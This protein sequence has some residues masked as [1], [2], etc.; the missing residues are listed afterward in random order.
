MNKLLLEYLDFIKETPIEDIS[1]IGDPN[2]ATNFTKPEIKMLQSEKYQK[3]IRNAFKNTPFVFDIVFTYHD[4][5]DAN[6]EEDNDEYENSLSIALK[7]AQIN[8]KSK[9]G[10][11]TFVSLG[12]LSSEQKLP[13]TPWILA[14]KIGHAITDYGPNS[15]GSKFML[16]IDNIYKIKNKISNFNDLFLF[17]SWKNNNIELYESGELPIELIA[18]YLIKGEIKANTDNEII[19]KNVKEM[20]DLLFEKFNSLKGKVLNGV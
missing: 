10:I 2:T 17:K 8:I 12:N 5:F 7:P 16:L 6:S 20:N 19:L 4:K 14:H 13:M 3:R 9:P 11:I 1:H 18:L 15:I